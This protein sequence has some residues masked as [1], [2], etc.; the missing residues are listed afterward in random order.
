MSSCFAEELR[1]RWGGASRAGTNR[2]DA[3]RGRRTGVRREHSAPGTRLRTPRLRLR[4]PEVLGR[5]F[6][7]PLRVVDPHR[8]DDELCILGLVVPD[9]APGLRRNADRLVLAELDDLVVQLELQ[10]AR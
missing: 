1:A 6:R 10:P 4:R 8:D 2:L 9:A 5:P 7:I 3:S